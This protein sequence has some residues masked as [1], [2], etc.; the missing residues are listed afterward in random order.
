MK[1]KTKS[2][3][4]FTSASATPTPWRTGNR[5]ELLIN[6]DQFFPKMLDAINNANES[7]C[8]EMYLVESCLTTDTFINA[9]CQ[10][11]KR[12]VSVRLLLDHVGS[13]EFKHEDRRLLRDA[14]VSLH[15]YNRLKRRKKLNNLSRDHR[16]IL[17]IDSKL[18][19]IGGAGLTDNFNPNISKETAW[20]DIMIMGRGPVI[21]DWVALFNHSWNNHA[22]PHYTIKHWSSRYKLIKTTLTQYATETPQARVNSGRGL[23]W[24]P[25]KGSLITELRKS[26][27][28]AWISTAYFYPSWKLRREIRKAAVRGVD[29]RLLLPGTIT[30]HPSIR[31][32]GRSHYAKLLR[33]NVKIYEYQPAFMHMKIAAIDNWCSIGSCNFDRWNLRWN[34]EANQEIIDVE[35]SKKI[36][37][38]LKGD[39]KNSLRIDPREWHKRPWHE[40][41]NEKL[42]RIMSA[43]ISRF[44]FK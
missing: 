42:W 3:T 31:F 30:D 39:F 36:A 4:V 22:E 25:I 12:N 40:K 5:F 27:K 32:A 10:A 38:M 33:Y 16:K 44:L 21:E 41:L 15:F 11:A 35:F 2:A 26:K 8:L 29:V 34:L 24:T 18:V 20:R 9:F 13:R 19:F 28:T 7:I 23:G 43:I 17:L 14:G 1:N 37:S 6:G